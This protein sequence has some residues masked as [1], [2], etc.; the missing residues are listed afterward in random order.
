M[1]DL[2][3]DIAT[4]TAII[5]GEDADVSCK[6]SMHPDCLDGTIVSRVILS[7]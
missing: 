1:L 5:E 4:F 7:L 2:M 3:R 6:G